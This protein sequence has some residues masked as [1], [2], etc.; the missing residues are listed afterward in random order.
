[1][2]TVDVLNEVKPVR[3]D[4]AVLVEFEDQILPALLAGA[5]G[6]ICDL[7]NIAPELFVGLLPVPRES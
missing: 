3:P 6:S 2:H 1:M 5:A 7:S 4:F